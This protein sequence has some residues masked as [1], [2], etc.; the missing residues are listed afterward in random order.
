MRKDEFDPA[1]T[2]V[3]DQRGTRAPVTTRSYTATR[4]QDGGNGWVI[5]RVPP[6]PTLGDQLNDVTS[7]MQDG[8]GQMRRSLRDLVLGAPDPNMITPT[9]GQTPYRVDL[10]RIGAPAPVTT[11]RAWP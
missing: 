9:L 10:R 11:M 8:F 7:R 2:E 6:P 3:E 5:R 4:D 1:T